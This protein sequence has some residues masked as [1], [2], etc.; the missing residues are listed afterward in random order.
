MPKK[1]KITPE[2]MEYFKKTGA[3]GG[4]ARAQ[5]HTP[6]ELSAWGRQGGRPKGSSKKAPTTRPKGGK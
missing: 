4:K 2:A 5:Q 1:I 3:Q 6:E